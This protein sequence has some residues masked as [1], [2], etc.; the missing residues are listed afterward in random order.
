MLNFGHSFGHA[1]E[2]ETGLP[3]GEAVAIG[4]AMAFRLSVEHGLCPPADADRAIAH[5]ESVGL[6]TATS[7]DPA[8]LA[9][10]MA[11]DKKGAARILTRGIGKA[12]L[13]PA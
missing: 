13:E 6:P 8:R 3:H 2:A 1:I 10:R 7:V 12:F 11:H 4:M 5:I 9:A